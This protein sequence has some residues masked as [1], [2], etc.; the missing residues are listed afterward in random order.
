MYTIDWHNVGFK[1]KLVVEI[2]IS[3]AIGWLNV[4]LK[5]QLLD[6]MSI[7]ETIDVPNGHPG[8]IAR[9][10]LCTS[11]NVYHCFGKWL[12]MINLVILNGIVHF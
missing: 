9:Y 10:L 7:S 8:Q 2:S 4:G 1:T 5:G 11:K 3:E 12:I 6:E